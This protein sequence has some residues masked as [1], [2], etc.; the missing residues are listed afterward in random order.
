[1]V[2]CIS[3]DGGHYSSVQAGTDMNRNNRLAVMDRLRQA[4]RAVFIGLQR[5]M[6]GSMNERHRLP[7]QEQDN[8]Q[9]GCEAS[10]MQVHSR[11]RYHTEFDASRKMSWFSLKVPDSGAV[12]TDKGS[13]ARQYSA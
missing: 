11:Q 9:P 5:I 8:K 7:E 10:V 3:Q 1:M 12:G 4:L 6:A 13:T 2:A